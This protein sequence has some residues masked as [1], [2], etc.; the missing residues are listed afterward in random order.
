MK[1]PVC[2]RDG[3]KEARQCPKI[4]GDAVCE[5]CC[6]RCTY[7]GQNGNPCLYYSN[8]PE[9]HYQKDLSDL[10]RRAE[11]LRKTADRLWERN[12]NYAASQKEAEW[13]NAVRDIM[14]LE[15]ENNENY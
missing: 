15:E 8:S 7:R 12:M 14:K 10:K 11:F 9:A 5:P 1:C 4:K 13:R 2:G 6:R 3:I